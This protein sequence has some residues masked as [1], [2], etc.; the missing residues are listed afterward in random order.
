MGKP[1]QEWNNSNKKHTRS[2]LMEKHTRDEIMGKN[3]RS[4]MIRIKN[5][6]GM[7]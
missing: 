1:Y 2:D 7:M 6:L 3:T 4:E 5:M